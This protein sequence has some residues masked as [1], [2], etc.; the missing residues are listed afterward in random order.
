MKTCAFHTL[1]C[2]VNQ[3]ETQGIRECFSG[4]G[5]TEVR[6]DGPSDVYIINTC[7]VTA[8][9][10]RESR[11]LIRRAH[12]RNP[13]GKI[14]VTGC[15][16]ERDDREIG[17]IPGVHLIV[18]NK[19]KNSIVDRLEMRK[20]AAGI[21][22]EQD[23]P[24]MNISDFKGMTKAY[25]KV[26][27]GCDNHCSYCKIPLVRGPSR[28]RDVESAIMEA[29]RLISKGFKELILTG[30]CLGAWG[31]DLSPR[32]RLHELL[33]R[34][35][36]IDGN[37]RIRLSSIEPKYVDEPLLRSLNRSSKM[38][39]HLHVPLQ[40]GDNKIL[41]MMNRPY[42]ARKYTAMAK[43]ARHIV[44][45]ISITTDVLVGFPSETEG[46]FNNTC[47]LVKNV[48]PSRVH[49]FRYS[50]R[51]GTAASALKDEAP[52]DAVRKRLKKINDL[53]ALT[54]LK[55]RKRFKNKATDVLIESERD[56]DTGMLKGYDDKYV[57]VLLEGPDSYMSKIMTV[58]IEKVDEGTTMG[59]L[60]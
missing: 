20:N 36:A 41:C 52:S 60:V 39:K 3:Y 58:R 25:L 31:E 37:F 46:N 56:T 34:L 33:E 35:A 55:Y 45:D 21:A 40:S 13:S 5:Y 17:D 6:F 7:T 2:K 49:V 57:K 50:R 26:Q 47:R 44:P 23:Y 30:I 12:R 4:A 8:R 1:G 59:V 18:R 28:S 32:M 27:D 14:V 51:E 38:C 16:T 22:R 29:R 9:A 42:T 15:Y 19:D 24:E 43:A 48:T 54:S 11:H 10:D 53:A